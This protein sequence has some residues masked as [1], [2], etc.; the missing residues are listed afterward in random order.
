MG[1]NRKNLEKSL[2]RFSYSLISTIIGHTKSILPLATKCSS[3]HKVFL[4]REAHQRLNAQRDSLGTSHKTTY[5]YHI[6][7]FQTTRRK[8]SI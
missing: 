8:A 5:A 4:P 3:M 1:E 7:K 6:T 2:C